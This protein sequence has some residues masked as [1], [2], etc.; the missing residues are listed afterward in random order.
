MRTI[1]EVISRIKNLVKGVKQDAFLT[2]RVVFSLVS[3]HS[4]MLMRRQDSANKLMKFNPVFQSIP[5]VELIEIDKVEAQC[6]GIKSECTIKRTKN[7]LPTF[8]QGYWGPLIRSVTSIDSSEELQPTYPTT[9]LNISKQKNFKYNKTKYYWFINDYLYFPNLEWDA[10]RIEGVFEGD[11]SIF[12]CDDCIKKCAPQRQEQQFNVPDFLDTEIDKLVLE[13][14][15]VMLRVP[16]DN[17]DD[18]QALTR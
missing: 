16:P 4:K 12:G 14:L 15:G 5:F 11:I 8:M 18:K 9:Y 3:K 10:V 17:T 2:D 6:A 13:D 1:G 7:K